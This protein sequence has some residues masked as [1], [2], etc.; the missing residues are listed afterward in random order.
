[1]PT[2]KSFYAIKVRFFCTA[3]VIFFSQFSF[4]QAP[5][6]VAPV[7]TE[8]IARVI[9][10]SGT[11]VA[12]FDAELS[13]EISGIVKTI[14]KRIGQKVARGE[15]LISLDDTLAVH[16][17]QMAKANVDDATIAYNDAVR[18]LNELQQLQIKQSVAEST[19]RD[20]QAA[21]Q[22][23]EAA[24]TRARTQ[25]QRDSEIVARH[26]IKAPFDGIIARRF[27]DPGEWVNPGKATLQMVAFEKLWLDFSVPESVLSE[28]DKTPSLTYRTQ[29]DSR[30]NAA[31]IDAIIPVADINSRSVTL[32]ARPQTNSGLYPGMAINGTLL[33]DS[34][35]LGIT[36]SRDA[37]LRRTDGSKVVWTV[38]PDGNQ[39]IAIENT[40]QIGQTMGNRVEIISGLKPDAKTVVRGNESLSPEQNVS[41]VN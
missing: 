40:V 7:A 17:M 34:G 29:G 25:W 12:D 27:V 13:A 14:D 31:D 23:K 37:I 26:K 11:V 41:V 36:V 18:R 28:L 4:A 30:D 1:M 21:V 39:F 22:Q 19:I 15:N 2:R 16:T 8:S 6:H 3:T 33:I 35:R 20:L 5:V 24:L 38:E 9:Q 10:I 32:R